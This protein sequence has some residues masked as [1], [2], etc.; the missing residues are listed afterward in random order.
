MSNIIFYFYYFILD[1]LVGLSNDIL[2]TSAVMSLDHP[3][4]LVGR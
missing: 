4:L 3:I 2:V 1:W